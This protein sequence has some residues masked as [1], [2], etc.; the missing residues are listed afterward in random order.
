MSSANS[1][2]A[3]IGVPRVQTPL[4]LQ[5]MSASAISSARPIQRIAGASPRALRDTTSMLSATMNAASRP[6]P[7]CP[8]NWVRPRPK[9]FVALRRTT[10]GREQ[11]GPLCGDEANPGIH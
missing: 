1:A 4:S 11:L 6:M 2:G 7:N 9:G 8:M 3:R 10:D 5:S